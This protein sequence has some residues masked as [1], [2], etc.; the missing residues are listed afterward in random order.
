MLRSCVNRCWLLISLLCEKWR[1]GRN[2]ARQ[3]GG[4]PPKSPGLPSLGIYKHSQIDQL[5][6]WSTKWA[7]VKTHQCSTFVVWDQF[8]WP[9]AA[10]MPEKKCKVERR[11]IEINCTCNLAGCSKAWKVRR[12][13]PDQTWEG[14]MGLQECFRYV[15]RVCNITYDHTLF[16]DPS[17][18]NVLTL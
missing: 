9:N 13:C 4:M 6:R 8:Q 10:H 11:N 12:Q 14:K 16:W 3:E 15:L 7:D 1:N 18:L 5:S 17:K 2:R